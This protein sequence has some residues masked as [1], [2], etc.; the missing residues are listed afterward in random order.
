M[1]L[2]DPVNIVGLSELINS[3]NGDEIAKIEQDIINGAKIAINKDA[4][5]SKEYK[6]EMQR[7]VSTFMNNQSYGA[8]S[9][10]NAHNNEIGMGNASHVTNT[11]GNSFHIIDDDDDPYQ[12]DHKHSNTRYDLSELL[13][14]RHTKHMSNHAVTDPSD[15]N[16]DIGSLAGSN[17]DADSTIYPK[18]SNDMST[19]LQ[20]IYQHV[21][22]DDV[23]LQ[24]KAKDNNKQDFL[25]HILKDLNQDTTVEDDIFKDKEDDEKALYMDQIDLLRYT[26]EDDGIPIDNVPIA[27]LDMPIANI[28]HIHKTLRLKEMRM[29]RTLRQKKAQSL[30]EYSLILI[31]VLGAIYSMTFLSKRA[32]MGKLRDTHL[33]MINNIQE[34]RD[35]VVSGS[36]LEIGQVEQQYEPYYMHIESTV[37]SRSQE[38]LIMTGRRGPNPETYQRT[39]DV[40]TLRRSFREELPFPSLG[41]TAAVGIGT[42]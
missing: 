10:N 2:N 14:S 1:S 39:Y 24:R 9:T 16:R 8:Q 37:E 20:S 28:K 35:Q 4:D 41:T 11:S 26:L 13:G 32:L 33:Y 7:L 36:S 42:T 30:T 23:Y 18:K 22:S 21:N 27:T 19:D 6:N 38:E 29:P 17:D 12:N 5:L 3:D 31:V 40:R 34:A 15:S 25:N